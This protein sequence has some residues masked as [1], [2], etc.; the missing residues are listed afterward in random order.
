MYKI[1]QKV[2]KSYPN[3]AKIIVLFLGMSIFK[4]VFDYSHNFYIAIA[5]G[6]GF[7]II[8]SVVVPKTGMFSAFSKLWENMR[9]KLVIKL[10]V[11]SIVFWMLVMMLNNNIPLLAF[12]TIFIVL[13]IGLI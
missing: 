1:N 3:Y 10:F 4:D 11:F 8:G 7:I 6:I 5:S 12:Y 13:L 2:K 9:N